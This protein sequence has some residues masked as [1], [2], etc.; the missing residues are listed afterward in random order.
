MQQLNIPAGI[1]THLDAPAH[2]IAS[3][4]SVEQISLNQLIVPC[5]VIDISDKAH[6]TYR[7]NIDD[8]LKHEYEHGTITKGCFVIF[9]TGWERWWHEPDKYRNN[10]NF[11]SLSTAVAEL[12]LTRHIV[13]IGIDTLSPDAGGLDFPVHQLILGAGKYIVENIFNANSL[14]NTGAYVGIFPM[15]IAEG[16]ESPVRLIGIIHEATQ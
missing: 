15:K 12:L 2:C 8:I 1:G 13:G 14:P 7:I 6:E 9:Y 11:P 16:T 10:L 5:I 3:G 4:I